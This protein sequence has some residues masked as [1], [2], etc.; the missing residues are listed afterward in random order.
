[1]R[2]KVRNSY[3]RRRLGKNGLPTAGA[4]PSKFVVGRQLTFG[5][6]GFQLESSDRHHAFKASSGGRRSAFK[7]GV[8]VDLVWRL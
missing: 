4:V 1:M 2:N 7:V 8:V 6:L 5:V 3:Q